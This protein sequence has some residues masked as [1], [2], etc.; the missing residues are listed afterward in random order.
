VKDSAEISGGNG[1]QLRSYFLHL[2]ATTLR[3]QNDVDEIVRAII[4]A[5]PSHWHN[6]PTRNRGYTSFYSECRNM[7]EDYGIIL[8]TIDTDSIVIQQG[9]RTS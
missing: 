8:A 2:L 4:L 5:A 1:R 3:R 6:H 7:A 9:N